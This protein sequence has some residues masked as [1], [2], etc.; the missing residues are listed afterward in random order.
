MPGEGARLRTADTLLRLRPP[1]CSF[2]FLSPCAA[3]ALP[4][5]SKPIL[6]WVVHPALTQVVKEPL[7]VLLL[8]RLNMLKCLAHLCIR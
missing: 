2:S 3:R 5:R 1:T 7:A 4:G 6:L 8:F